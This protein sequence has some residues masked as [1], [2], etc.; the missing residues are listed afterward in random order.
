MAESLGEKLKQAREERDITISEVAEQTRISPL[1]L[2]SIDKDDYRPLPGGIFNKGFIKSYAKYVGVD[3]NE[4]MQDY[5]RLMATQGPG[6]DEEETKS[7]RSQVMVD[8]S[9]GRSMIPTVIGA[10]II[11]GLM[12]WGLLSLVSYM[13]N[14]ETPVVE[15]NVA[16]SNSNVNANNNVNANVNT[17]ETENATKYPT[18]KIKV[19]IKTSGEPVAIET[20][21]DGKRETTTITG[22]S[23]LTVEGQESVKI[24]YYKGLA[25]LIKLNLNGKDLE[26]PIPSAD[27]KR[28]AFVYEINKNNIEEVLQSGKIPGDSPVDA[29]ANTNANAAN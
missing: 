10:V 6:E 7:Y 20:F 11:L 23:A 25:G 12:T 24:S 18:D 26:T 21:T 4:A 17:A 8:D 28:N 19:E 29:N 1:Y 15:S 13:Q 14:R 9:G 27:Y 5:A 2:D 3:E 22:D 16:E